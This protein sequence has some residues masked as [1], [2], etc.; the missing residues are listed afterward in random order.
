MFTPRL[1]DER[2]TFT[3]FGVPH[4]EQLVAGIQESH[5]QAQDTPRAVALVG[6]KAT[7]PELF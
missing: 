7:Q 2:I 6:N 3:E 1:N 5:L 4:I